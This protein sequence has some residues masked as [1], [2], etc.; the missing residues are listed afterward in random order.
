[1]TDIL[2]T[3]FS[4]AFAWMEIFFFYKMSLKYVPYGLVDNMAALA[5]IMAWRRL[6]LNDLNPYAPLLLW[7]VSNLSKIETN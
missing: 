1:M 4:N 3:T 7:T 2:Q 6:G 5:Q